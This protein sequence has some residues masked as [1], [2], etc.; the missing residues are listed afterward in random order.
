MPETTQINDSD[1]WNEVDHQ[2]KI[3]GNLS[4]DEVDWGSDVGEESIPE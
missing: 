3:C 4:T 2:E 1:F